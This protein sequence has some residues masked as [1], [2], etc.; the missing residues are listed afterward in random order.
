M[1]KL[2]KLPVGISSF[3]GIRQGGFLYVDKT[4]HIFRMV[5]EGMYY[6]MSRPRRFGK[7]LAVSTLKCLLQGRRDLFEKLW[8][9]EREDFDWKAHPVILI[10]FNGIGRDTPEELKQSPH[11]HLLQT[12]LSNGIQ[13]R[14]SVLTNLFKELIL[15]LSIKSGARVAILIDE[16]DKPLIDHL[17]KGREALETAKA[18]RDV[19][20]SFLGVV[21][22]GEVSSVSR[23]VFVTG[24]SKFSRVSIFSELNNLDDLTM[25]RRYADFMGYTQQE[26]ETSF[27]GHIERFAKERETSPDRIA[28]VL[29]NRYDGYR[30]S[31]KDVRVYNPFSVLR[32]LGERAFKNYWFETGTPTFLVNL[33]KENG[34]NLP[35]IEEMKAGEGVFST[36]DLDHLKPEAV[37]F[38]TGYVTIK[39]IKDRLYVFGYPNQEVKTAFL[40]TLFHSHTEGLRESSLFLRLAVH[41]EREDFESFFETISAIFSSIPHTLQTKR[42]EA[43]F[44]TLFYLMVCASGI[45]ARSEVLVCE[46]RIDLAMEFSEKI[47]IIEFKCNHSA[48]DAIRQIKENGYDR[49]YRADGKKLILMGIDFDTEKRIVAAWKTA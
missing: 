13:L 12:A 33:L 34:W 47:F 22:D 49:K 39:D 5:D 25:N 14:S 2:Q 4:R 28:R 20:K 46:G 27:A 9:A 40:E 30:F 44:H 16:Y 18:N 1:T 8:I 17:G 31:E 43:Y 37:L 6:F 11:E 32:A 35:K 48:D 24:V 42:D 21:K 23:F 19:L 36:F 15:S 10:D 38:Q 29:K 26:L 7:S 3:E 45:D 41:L